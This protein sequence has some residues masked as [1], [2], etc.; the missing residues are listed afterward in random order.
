MNCLIEVISGRPRPY[1]KIFSLLAPFLKKWKLWV[2]VYVY[3]ADY[4]F[5]YFYFIIFVTMS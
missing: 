1:W 2:Y 4:L 5:F 3:N